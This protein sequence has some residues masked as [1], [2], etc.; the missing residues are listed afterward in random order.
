MASDTSMVFN[1]LGRDV[2]VSGALNVIKN[3]FRSAGQTAEAA[4]DKASTSTKRLDHEIDQTKR[5][6]AELN[7]EFART[8]DK[9]LFE[10]ISKDR[11][12]LANLQRIRAEVKANNDEAGSNNFGKLADLFRAGAAG[13]STATSA[14]GGFG[15]TVGSVTSSIWG[16]AA[17]LAGV[18]AALT[19]IG[20]GLAL[21]GGA[22]GS[23]PGLI[24]GGIAGIGALKLGLT[25]LSSEYT[26]LTTATGGGGGGATKAAKDF[27]AATRAVQSAVEQLARSE[28][29]VTTAQKEAL[30]TQLAITAAR[31]AASKRI[32]DES[33]SL[34]SAQLDQKDAAQAVVDAQ[35]ALNVAQA[36]G[37]TGEIDK[38]KE[39]YDRAVI[40]AA[41]AKNKVD[42]LTEANDK[43][44]K[45][46]VEGSD[47]VVQA[48]QREVDA[49]QR[50]ADSIQA[51]RDAEL[52]LQDAR[53]SLADEQKKQASGGGGGAGQKVTELAPAARAFLDTILGLRPAFT[54]L[55]LDVQQQLF[56]GLARPIK[57]L[58]EKWLPQLHRTL[59]DFAGT[60]NGIAKTA[61]ATAGKKTFIHDMAAGA[62]GVRKALGEI[63]KVAAGPLLDAFGRLARASAPFVEKLGHL[64]AGSLKTFSAWIKKADESGKLTSF[65]KTAADTL[66][67][68]WSTGSK[69]IGVLG[70]I[71]ALIFPSAISG[72][73][74]VFDKANNT[75]DKI[76]AWLDKPSTQAG[77]RAVADK[78]KDVALWII[79][80]SVKAVGFGIAVEKAIGWVMWKGSQLVSFFGALPGKMS[81][82]LSSLWDGLKGGFRGALNWIIDM[83][84]SLHFSVPSVDIFGMHLGGGT[85]G[86]PHINHL[87]AGGD[88]TRSGIAIVGERG[89]EPVYLPAGASVAPHSSLK[90]AMGGGGTLV[91][92][93][94]GADADMKRMI[95]KWFRT[96]N[97]GND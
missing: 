64:L 31:E 67:K 54:N 81:Q 24:G 27:T 91:I 79:H 68:V 56:A 4:M 86:V 14:L 15:S 96:D 38:A 85:I 33:L 2:S 45:T 95:R 26:R 16:I 83:W 60:F 73:N 58:A 50:V 23:L 94:R 55:R 88:V 59:G 63:G 74:S 57:G 12:L 90:S 13:A 19:A 78:F 9:G 80:A 71:I 20:P 39:A 51:E 66:G 29:D 37:N 82:A 25:G 65:F 35:N 43:N 92:D 11:S 48:K 7:A 84:N 75:L 40:A 76:S 47:E 70:K 69:I 62:D 41:E 34:Q 52:R 89:P 42:D 22:L 53:K 93:I 44:A 18:V 77:I 10:K 72:G 5:H 32:R 3:A 1:L 49:R 17:A 8:G 46:G 87:A 97:L 21:A 6:L 61:I 36:T 30:A 28:R